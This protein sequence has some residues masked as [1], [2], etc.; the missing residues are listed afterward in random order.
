[1]QVEPISIEESSEAVSAEVLLSS[2]WLYIVAYYISIAYYIK[3][4]ELRFLNRNIS[5]PK[6]KQIQ[7]QKSQIYHL[8]SIRIA[9]E[10]VPC[11]SEYF[12]H[13]QSSLKNHYQI[14][15]FADLPD[16]KLNIFEPTIF[17]GT[18][19][20]YFQQEINVDY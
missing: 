19:S 17:S 14:D 13:I 6:S 2:K 1:M 7:F 10:Y 12:N 8:N 3:A 11:I 20:E 15:L 9:I 5:D 18:Q 4:T 16:S